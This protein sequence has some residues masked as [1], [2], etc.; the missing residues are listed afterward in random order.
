MNVKMD[1]PVKMTMK[2]FLE[3]PIRRREKDLLANLLIV[4]IKRMMD[5]YHGLEFQKKSDKEVM[6]D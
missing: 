2:T 1:I 3:I 4:L 5:F 6:K